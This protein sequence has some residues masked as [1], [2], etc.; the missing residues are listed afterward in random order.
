MQSIGA[1]VYIDGAGEFKNDIS[2]MIQATKTFKSELDAINKADLNP[3]AK[4]SLSKNALTKEIEA[5]EA[6]IAL[7]KEK[8]EESADKYGENAK[9]TLKWQ[10]QLAKANA[11]LASMQE[12]LKAIKNPLEIVGQQ[13]KDF[14][15]N[16]KDF[17]RGVSGTGDKMTRTVTT[18]IVAGFT[19]AGKAAVDFESAMTGVQKTVDETANTSYADLAEAI[20]QMSGETGVAKEE[21]AGVME[22]AGQLG[23]SADDIVDFTKTMIDMGVS[24][25]IS[26]DE[27]ATALARFINI[28]GDDGK[29]SN[30]GATIVALGNNFATTESE[31]VE[32]AQR[33][34]S[35]GTNAGLASTDIL[36][37]ATAMSSVGIQA[38][39]GGTAMTQTL[40]AM[41]A[42]V[43]HYRAGESEEL[44]KIA[45]VA[46]MSA[47]SFATAW[48][49]KPIDA[50]QA[51]ITGLAGLDEKGENATLVL[52]E[53]GMSGVRQSNML[54]SLA[55]ASEQLTGAIAMSGQAFAQNSALAEE[56]NKRYGTTEQRI[57][58]LKERLCTLAVEV[59][60]RLLPYV[61]KFIDFADRLLEKWDSL[62]QGTQ[63]MIMKAA[64][65]TATV[66]PILSIGGR[67]ISGIGSLI[68]IG[69]TLLGGAGKLIHVIGGI[70]TALPSV[71]SAI[72][73]IGSAAAGAAGAGGLGALVTAAAPFLAGGAI[74]AGIGFGVYEIVKHWDDIKAAAKHVGEFLG[75]CWDGITHV[76]QDAWNGLTNFLDDTWKGITGIVEDA[77][78]GIGTFLSGAW[79]GI[80]SAASTA[81]D[82]IT[83]VIGGAWDGITSTVKD[84]ADGLGTFLSG[85]W[86]GISNTASSAWNGLC[87]I[88]GR[89]WSGISNTVMNAASGLA[90]SLSGVWSGIKNAASS[91][92]NGIMDFGRGAL[93]WGG[94]LVS[95]VASGISSGWNTVKGAVSD[96]AGG[97]ADFLGFSEPDKGPLSNFHTFMPDMIDLMTKGI[98]QN[99]GKVTDA[100]DA[101]AS[102]LVPDAEMAAASTTPTTNNTVTNGDIVLNVYGAEGQDVNELADI[103][104]R[105][106]TVQVNRQAVVYG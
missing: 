52:D 49:E 38:E 15:G 90:N 13:M 54:R 18:P 14:G 31:I 80:S 83:G 2:T 11:A 100:A 87:D 79:D 99:M 42:A 59:G 76:A 74:V 77:A 75:D 82:G 48:E 97:I 22:A 55:L 96:I 25:N 98:Y 45:D 105:K 44:T 36:A 21:I 68:S 81:W 41:V 37:L 4:A 60:E 95:N 26:A 66:G 19:M 28:T 89:A 6:K 20:K 47:E 24:T 103:V 50:V 65:I 10:E 64:L 51:F 71:A 106:L 88:A 73:G 1:K 92:F 29:V 12:E 3:F 57:L 101:L 39:A 23:I 102:V 56:A 67:L 30:L 8:L 33:L 16:M 63:D 70:G 34:A 86:E 27:A 84:A 7:L 17:G 85:A 58:A 94:D 61:D 9:Q 91:A 78:D 5:Q 53:L 35:A 62:D 104:M 32:M 72:G 43:A 93:K 46:N 40:N 69:G